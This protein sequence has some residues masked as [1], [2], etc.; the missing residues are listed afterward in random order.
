VKDFLWENF[1]WIIINGDIDLTCGPNC[2]FL[3][4]GYGELDQFNVFKLTR[5][6]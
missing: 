5:I 1:A 2:D 6:I 4:V 3:A